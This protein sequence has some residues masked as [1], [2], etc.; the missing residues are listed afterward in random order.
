[1]VNL[2][3][4]QRVIGFFFFTRLTCFGCFRG[5]VLFRQASMKMKMSPLSVPC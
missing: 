2:L 3:E 4:T 1:M 5:E